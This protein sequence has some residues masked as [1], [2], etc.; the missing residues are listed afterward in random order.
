MISGLK[1]KRH[2]NGEV[3][4]LFNPGRAP[5]GDK[6]GRWRRRVYFRSRCRCLPLWHVLLMMEADERTR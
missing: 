3:Q 2:K 6:R 1:I 5:Y 4:S